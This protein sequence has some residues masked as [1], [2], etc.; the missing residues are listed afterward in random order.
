MHRRRSRRRC[1]AIEENR[2]HYVQTT[3]VARRRCCRCWLQHLTNV[4]IAETLFI[5]VRTVESHVSAFCCASSSSL[6]RRSLA[7]RAE[8]ELTR[9]GH[10]P[11]V[12]PAGG[13]DAARRAGRRAGEAGGHPCRSPHGHGDRTRRGRQ[14]QAR[15]QRRSRHRD[16]PPRRRLVRRPRRSD[17]PG[18][19]HA[20]RPRRR[21]AS[22]SSAGSSCRVDVA[23]DPGAERRRAPPRQLR[24][25]DRRGEVG[26]RAESLPPARP[27]PSSRT[28][29]CLPDPARGNGCTR[30]RACRSP[31][32]AAMPSSCSPRG[33]PPRTTRR[34]PILG[35]SQAC[36]APLNPEWRSPSSSPW[37]GTPRWAWTGSRPPSTSGCG[38]S[39]SACGWPTGTARSA[40]RS[41][42]A[43]TSWVPTTRPCCNRSRPSRCGSRCRGR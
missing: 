31:T 21:S 28:S 29:G 35:A 11:S 33:S 25:P 6:D 18:H 40:T 13:D 34:R 20:R 2:S 24:A 5:S 17:R 12:H 23:R 3:G 9:S 10:S 4:Q 39:P 7:R 16:R 14:D 1:A 38:S 8:A 36:A 27:S 41:R 37:P 26:D 42:G 15:T 32:T 19:G 30:C 22:P 43:T